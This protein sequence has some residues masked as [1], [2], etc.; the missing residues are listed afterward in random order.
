MTSFCHINYT[1]AFFSILHTSNAEEWLSCIQKGAVRAQNC[2]SFS[3]LLPP[4]HLRCCPSQGGVFTSL[5]SSTLCFSVFLRSGCHGEHFAQTEVPKKPI[6]YHRPH[7]YLTRAALI[8]L[9]SHTKYYMTHFNIEVIQN[10]FSS[11]QNVCFNST[12]IVCLF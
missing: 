10:F 6:A 9:H 3:F 8:R 4:S 5:T 2:S 7:L 1:L 11:F 12:Y